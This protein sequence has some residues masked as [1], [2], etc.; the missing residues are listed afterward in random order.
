MDLK[1]GAACRLDVKRLL[2]VAAAQQQPWLFVRQGN[3]Y[4]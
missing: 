2:D 4:M 1:V 3:I